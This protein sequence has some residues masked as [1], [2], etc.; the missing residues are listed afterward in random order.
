MTLIDSSIWIDHIRAADEIL[1]S[2]IE[3]EQVLIHPF[4]IGEIALGAI[5]SRD[6]V[7]EELEKLPSAPVADHA[8][9][10]S[11]IEGRR[12]YGRGIGYVDA[13]LLAATRLWR[14]TTLWT[15][16]RRLLAVAEEMGIAASFTH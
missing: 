1:A 4:V 10:M 9:V 14:G 8:E 16:D 15:R 12:L 13:H 3:H 2:L 5:R 6:A 11:L 7:L